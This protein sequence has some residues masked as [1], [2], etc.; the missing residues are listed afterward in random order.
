MDRIVVMGAGHPLAWRV[1]A[2]FLGRGH[3][4]LA[5]AEAPDE[6]LAS[7][8]WEVGAL[9]D[10]ASSLVSA[11]EGA[12][13]VF[14]FASW[15]NPDT[16]LA[17]VDGYVA[18]L[19]QSRGRPTVL[20]GVGSLDVFGETTD[21]PVDETAGGT[22]AGPAASYERAL[23]SLS[24]GRGRV[25]LARLAPCLRW[26]GGVASCAWIHED[27]AMRLLVH[28]AETPSL[29]GALHVVAPELCDGRG[30]RAVP[31]KALATGFRFRY[32][33]HAAAAA[34]VAETRVNWDN[35]DVVERVYWT[36]ETAERCRFFPGSTGRYRLSIKGLPVAW[37]TRRERI[38]DAI[39]GEELARGAFHTFQRRQRVT[40]AGDG[41]LVE[42]AVAF[43]VRGGALLGRWVNQTV[44]ERLFAALDSAESLGD[45]ASFESQLEADLENSAPS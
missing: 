8:P 2:H 1:A 13:A 24:H 6:R 10:D 21:V 25:V 7:L 27:D 16:T 14:H 15:D 19:E 42:D 35:L 40:P 22:T 20:V 32:P 26:T 12:R 36:R 37:E 4:V 33:T 28:A 44:R 31:A 45:P 30:V 11:L 38:S 3:S 17:R 43:R 29:E 23:R 5:F 18:A 41:T 39:D 9:S 34:K